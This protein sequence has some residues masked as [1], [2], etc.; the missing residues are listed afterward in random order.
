MKPTA[1][2]LYFVLLAFGL[3][4]AGGCESLLTVSFLAPIASSW[5]VPDELI[6]QL[7]QDRWQLNSDWSP[8]GG[9]PKTESQDTL[10]WVYP[11]SPLAVEASNSVDASESSSH[12]L[13]AHVRGAESLDETVEPSGRH[14]DGFRTLIPLGSDTRSDVCRNAVSDASAI[15]S[16]AEQNSLAGWN[17]LILWTQQN[18]VM[19]SDR[20]ID[21]LEQLVRA[22]LSTDT[23]GDNSRSISA[24]SSQVSP[25]IQ[26][27][28]A[29]AWCLA[30]GHKA[31]SNSAE[32][33]ERVLA[34]A[35]RLLLRLG[36]PETVRGELFR[37][38]ARWIPP[39]RIP[40]L[41]NAL[42]TIENE[43]SASVAIR[44]AALEACLLF[45]VWNKT[46][47]E[48]PSAQFDPLDW[49]ETIWQC[50]RDPDPTIRRLFGQ[51]LAAA[52]PPE[53][54]KL[55]IAQFDDGS[56][57]VREEA[58]VSAGR[59][60]TADARTA[61]REQAEREEPRRRQLAVRGLAQWGSSELARFV[62]DPAFVVR[63]TVAQ[64]LARF[65][66][67]SSVVLL[68][69]LLADPS[70]RVQQDVIDTTRAWPDELAI[71]VLLQGLVDCTLAN[72]M[73]C[74][75]ALER[76]VHAS[77]RVAVEAPREERRRESFEIAQ[78]MGLPRGVFTSLQEEKAAGVRTIDHERQVKVEEWLTVLATHPW[79]SDVTQDAQKQLC[80]LTPQEISL[81]EK[82]AA[83]CSQEA[84]AILYRHVLPELSPA[85]AALNEL[86]SPDVTARRRAAQ[87]LANIGSS[88]SLPSLVVR[89][90]HSLMANEQDGLVWRFAMKAVIQDNTD[91]AAQL[92]LL[93]VN[94]AWPDIRILGCRYVT[95]HGRPEYAL[96]LLPLLAEPNR[97]V[98]L[99]A[100]RAAGLCRNPVVLDG[101]VAYD[102]A[103]A[104]RP[105]SGLRSLLV[106]NDTRIRM[107]AAV[108]MSRLGDEQGMQ[109]L[110][111]LSYQNDPIVRVEIV[112]QIGE[113][114]QSRFIEH[115]IR[116]A[117]TET[118]HRVK[119]AILESLDRLVPV[120]D[121]P[122]RLATA[123][124]EREQIEA[125]AEWWE[126]RREPGRIAFQGLK[127]E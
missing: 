1:S 58:F 2:A 40:R 99:E 85:Y 107:A 124:G 21:R 30:L 16:L 93:A 100:V 18:P 114:G 38:C 6:Q 82:H 83:S 62:N 127:D 49:P 104:E 95:R 8:V 73:R 56:H 96:W 91:E 125:W 115:L 29:E 106:H 76:R 31:V 79:N 72:R 41:A 24:P 77:I 89:R 67:A 123:S 48:S 69:R 74:R 20:Q 110:M 105:S 98:Q 34:P 51:W 59:L 57:S 68:Q 47:E 52:Q 102:D 87:D 113:T 50:E 11:Q 112:R 116:L 60:G 71:P 12:K 120:Q 66:E 81:V 70:S 42:S 5:A 119:V 45:A 86:D 27:A 28:A 121:R 78:D 126:D 109:E 14:W 61:L 3:M 44:R 37:G 111:R 15:Q 32:D 7:A 25:A 103:N 122:A 63:Q 84:A 9:S 53:A 88:A 92:A 55:L 94:H 33:R 101:R 23:E 108:S 35:G 26:S 46:D 43:K 39:D 118:H 75:E 65:A 97:E 90:L 54:L 17:A 117:W 13:E 64:E 22:S 80:H 19:A 36:L 10:R 4:T